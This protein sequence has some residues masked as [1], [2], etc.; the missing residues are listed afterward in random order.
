MKKKMYYNMRMKTMKRN[1]SNLTRYARDHMRQR[2]E[3]LSA[4]MRWLSHCRHDLEAAMGEHLPSKELIKAKVDAVDRSLSVL[5]AEDAS[6]RSQFDTFKKSISDLCESTFAR[7]IVEL[8]TGGNVRSR[9][10]TSATILTKRILSTY[11]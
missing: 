10:S 1:A 5:S 3:S 8:E 4:S 9:L 11:S 2:A 7:M 6:L